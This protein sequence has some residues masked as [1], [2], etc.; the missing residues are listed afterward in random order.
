MSNRPMGI[1]GL[2][3]IIAAISG[4]ALY[5]SREE[6]DSRK[7]Q[8]TVW[9]FSAAHA[10][11]LNT[12]VSDDVHVSL[13]PARAMDVRLTSMNAAD[14]QNAP[15]LVEIEIGSLGRH[16]RGTAADVPFLPLT[17]R[18]RKSGWYDRLSPQRLKAWSHDGE[19]FGVPLDVHPVVILYRQ[20]LF[21][22]A[23]IDL[24]HVRTW[25][26]LHASA[27]AFEGV[28]KSRQRPTRAMLLPKV[29]ADVVL[30]MLQQRGV[31]PVDAQGIVHLT[32]RRVAGTIA[33]YA[34]MVAGDLAVST[35]PSPGPAR[36]V[37]DLENGTT[38][39]VIVADW[40]IEELQANSMPEFRYR[41]GVRRLPIFDST[42][43]PT[44]SWG[45]TAVAIPRATTDPDGAWALLE[46]LY[47]SDAAR[48]VRARAGRPLPAVVDW[49]PTDAP[50]STDTFTTRT[51]RE[52]TAM[53]HQL[54]PRVVTPYTGMASGAISMVLYRATNA[55]EADMSDADLLAHIQQ[56]L[57]EA[58]AD[59]QSRIGFANLGHR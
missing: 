46:Q 26:Q 43:A 55:V 4:V 3:A 42:D 29:S 37:D 58:Q 56:W 14:A 20:D 39:M 30:M 45:G 23:R 52:F 33:F 25:E 9:T 6:S 38:A 51:H 59:L 19:I 53:A 10:V 40:A 11:D 17:D 34:S 35:E 12:L 49:W 41:L 8:S 31:D 44:A 16:F 13:V 27:I 15:D 54:P 7:A 21:D 32:D 28:M 1:I 24:T 18:L 5:A 47:L 36:W 2:L 57:A 50:A 22:Q 48:S